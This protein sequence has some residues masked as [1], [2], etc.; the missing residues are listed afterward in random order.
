MATTDTLCFGDAD[1]GVSGN[2]T[3]DGLTD[4]DFLPYHT[5]PEVGYGNGSRLT[6]EGGG[7]AR[8]IFQG[9]RTV[10]PE[11]R[12]VLG[13]MCRFDTTF[14]D[15]DFICIALAKSPNDHSIRRMI[16][17]YPV[18][19]GVG[20]SAGA[21]DP[22]F[23][24]YE[25]KGDQ[26]PPELHFFKEAP[27]DPMDPM[28]PDK[29][30]WISY[31]PASDIQV[32][33]RSWKPG[34]Q[35]DPMNPNSPI[36]VCWSAEIS[37][38]R[39]SNGGDWLDLNDDFGLYFDVVRTADNNMTVAEYTFPTGNPPL[40]SVPDQTTPD[41]STIQWGHGLIPSV[42]NPPGS[43][44]GL[45]VHFVNGWQGIGRRKPG[46]NDPLGST[47]IGPTGSED[48]ELVALIENSGDTK[49]EKVT[50]EFRFADWGLP[51]QPGTMPW[52]LPL[53]LLPN[54]TLPAD[55]NQNGGTATLTS[56]WPHA[57]VSGDYAIHPHQCMV[58]QLSSSMSVNF[59]QAQV[60]RNMDFAH[61][62]EVEREAVISGEGYPEPADGS[63]QL[64]FV[65]ET[66]MRRVNVAELLAE[67]EVTDP[68][69]KAMVMSTVAMA[70]R[71]GANVQGKNGD[72]RTA[73]STSFASSP[74]FA[75]ASSSP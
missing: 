12:L 62:S 75:P 72:S 73:S 9:V 53:H 71:D 37:F 44:L 61:L 58:V 5:T 23:P 49:A 67:K 47:I 45:G 48:N 14:D 31:S 52:D 30:K 3:I 17:I 21:G 38:P 34:R 51:A 54:P 56:Q 59:N 8:V 18:L 66:F 11:D 50:A 7:L 74:R 42:Q 55:V 40:D 36:E 46:T 27:T 26:P 65:L 28:D 39:V 57:Q 19:P 69:V 64:D 70:N 22:N 25:I 33:V 63:G 68:A 41:P 1:T 6:Y 13:F 4:Y 32:K 60:R 2:P 10:T 16:A 29:D 20:A 35:V 24:A 15:T 43:N